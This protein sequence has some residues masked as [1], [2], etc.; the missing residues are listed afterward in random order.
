M[1]INKEINKYLAEFVADL[2]QEALVPFYGQDICLTKVKEMSNAIK[3]K[4]E[5]R[6]FLVAIKVFS[7][8]TAEINVRPAS[9]PDGKNINMVIHTKFR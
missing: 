4:L 5:H 1:K 9:D 6:G 3:N 2:I 7:D 8:F